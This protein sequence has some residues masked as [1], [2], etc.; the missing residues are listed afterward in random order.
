[1]NYRLLPLTLLATASLISPGQAQPSGTNDVEQAIRQ[2]VAAYVQSFNNY[3]AAALGKYWAENGVSASDA[4]GE[5]TEGRDAI[6]QDFAQLFAD[7][8][9]VQL[10]GQVNSVRMIRPDVAE[11]EGQTTLFIS[12]SESVRSA[13]SAIMVKEGNEWLL[14]SSH[15]TDL[16]VPATPYD[17]LQD[18]EWL[19]GTWQDQSDDAEVTTTVRWSANRAF[20]IRSFNA[21]LGNEAVQGTQVIGWDPLGEQI[22]SWT[23]NSDGSFGE[24]TVAKHDDSWMIKKWQILGD[25]RLASGTRVLTRVDDDTISVKTI[26]E[27]VDGEP[28]PAS[29]AV[30]V[31]RIASDDA[32]P[33]SE[34]SR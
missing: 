10:S 14:S 19:V 20:L 1:M 5:R 21:Q 17:A 7:S 24:G 23:F 32:A 30:T 3:D 33:Q 6:Q 29:D 15:E 12:E 16:P 25:G 28:V 22:R 8:P 18:L 26:G 11:L 2:K 4:S 31:V 13:F 9:G 34:T 27:T